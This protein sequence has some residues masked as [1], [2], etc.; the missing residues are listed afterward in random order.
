[1]DVV[2]AGGHGQI[3]RHLERLL[4]DA[5]HRARGLIRKPDH[6]EDLE[7]AGAEPVL[8][9]LEA[10]EAEELAEVIG[11][12]DAIVFAAGAGPGSGPERKWAVDYGGV[13]K[14]I[15]VAKRNG[16]ERYVI[17]SSMGADAGADDDGGFGTYL[18][19]KG[20]ADDALAESGLAYTVIRPGALTDDPPAGTVSAGPKLGRGRIPRADVAATIVEVLGAPGTA[21]L[22]FDLIGGP[23]PIAAAVA[24][25][26]TAPPSG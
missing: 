5:G 22:R 19:A 17:V 15:D 12:A 10:L 21:G 8:G 11:D 23:T 2:I 16:I 6:A 14:L 13:V 25:L 1:M 20:Q 3:A 4:A 24:E 9:D 7:A 18:R 26:A